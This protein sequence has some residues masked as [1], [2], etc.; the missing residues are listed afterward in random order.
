MEQSGNLRHR[1]PNALLLKHIQI[2]NR[3]NYV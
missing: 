2:T 1:I 3:K